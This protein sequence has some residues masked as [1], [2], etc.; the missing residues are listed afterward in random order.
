MVVSSESSSLLESRSA[1]LPATETSLVAVPVE[2]ALTV[3]VIS[4]LSPSATP[5]RGQVTTPAA[6]EHE[7]WS[8]TAD[9]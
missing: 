5:P 3:I 1:S 4:T 8:G 9:T 7:P 2:S 6:S